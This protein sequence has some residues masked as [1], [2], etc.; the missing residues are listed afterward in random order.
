VHIFTPHFLDV[1]LDE[2][3]D[4]NLSFIS[5]AIPIKDARGIISCG[6]GDPDSWTPIRRLTSYEL[7]EMPETF[8]ASD[9]GY[10]GYPLL[11][12]DGLFV[13]DLSDERFRTTDK[14]GNLVCSFQFPRRSFR[15]PEHKKWVTEGLS[16]DFFFSRALHNVGI[17]SK[18]TRKLMI[19]H[20]GRGLWPSWQPCG[21]WKQDEQTKHK[22]NGTHKSGDF[23]Q[24]EIEPIVAGERHEHGPHDHAELPQRL[25]EGD[26]DRA[27]VGAPD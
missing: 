2:M 15:H 1:L 21:E 12:N 10:P 9:M 5:A 7:Q 22:W 14:A 19:A 11:H 13:A 27:I 18:V 3:I 6:V 24:V 4:H 17:P 23:Q 26:R 16:E 20:A 25:P 8:D